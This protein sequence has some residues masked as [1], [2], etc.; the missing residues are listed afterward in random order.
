MRNRDTRLQD[1]ERAD[2][3]R[4]LG[5]I[6][7]LPVR[8]DPDSAQARGGAAAWAWPV[9]G[10]IIGA[11]AALAAAIA[12]GLGLGPAIAAALALATLVVT[13]GAMHEDGLADCADGFWG[14]WEKTRRLEIMKD[15]HIGAY[16]VAALI[17]SFL[18]RW[19]ALTMLFAEGYVW[20]T[21][22]AAAALSRAPMV[23]LMR[24][25]PNARGTGLSQSVGQ[26]TLRAMQGAL[27]AA[28]VIGFLTTGFQIILLTIVVALATLGVAAIARAKIDGQTGDVL[29]ATQQVAEI[30]VLLGLVALN[31]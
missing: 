27:I 2:I 7:R 25:L 5:L 20:T 24:Q 11:I 4:A 6:S 29:G 28:L 23:V 1:F 21:L 17:L 22:I 31:S 12:L 30:A 19:S 26:P 15:S 14:G 13:T 16:G 18:L 3:A 8:V 9:A 10:G